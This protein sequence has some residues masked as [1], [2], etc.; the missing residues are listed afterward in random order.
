MIFLKYTY[1]SIGLFFMPFLVL[2]GGPWASPELGG[3][4]E[5]GGTFTLSTLTDN[6]YQ[7]YSE[8]GLSKQLSAK[9]VL[10]FRQISSPNDI[11]SISNE[12]VEFGRLNGIGNITLGLKYQVPASIPLSIGLDLSLNTLLENRNLGLRTGY[13]AYTIR[14]IFSTG[15]SS[16][17]NY[18]YIEIMPGFTTNNYSSD[19]TLNLEYGGEFAENIYLSLYGQARLAFEDG[20]FN[21]ADAEAF[22]LTGFY[23]DRQRYYIVGPK[24]AIGLAS[25]WGLSLAFFYINGAN[26]MGTVYSAKLGLYYQLSGKN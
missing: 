10:P 7:L 15:N 19:L 6:T 12:T 2:A 3:Y 20:N 13:D 11:K 4:F 5:F 23:V 1:T 9:A 16:A 18:Y 8:F 17:K 21:D 22:K 26:Q 14:P 24:F 25:K